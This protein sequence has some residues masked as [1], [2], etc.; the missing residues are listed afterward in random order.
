MA[1]CPDVIPEMIFAEMRTPF[2]VFL[3]FDDGIEG[4]L[5]LGA[6]LQFDGVF[7]PLRD[8]AYFRR[9]A[10]DPELGTIALPNGADL[11][12]IVLH[13]RLTGRPIEWA[14]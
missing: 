14:E 12:P 11:D 7:G 2:R 6:F 1:V 4:E 8:P 5:D 13:S 9:G 10:L 3:R